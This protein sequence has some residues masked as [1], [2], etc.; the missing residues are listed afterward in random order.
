MAVFSLADFNRVIPEFKGDIAQLP[1]FIKR[2]DT[3]HGSLNDAGQK[4][5]I[6]HL[7]F[8]LSGKAF[9]I[10]ES[11]K[12]ETWALL[13][14]ALQEGLKISKSAS[15]LQNELINLK[16]QPDQSAKEFSDA[17]KEKLKELNDIIQ[18]QYNNDD[19]ITSFKSEYDKI[20]VRSFKEGLRPPL[21]HRIVN[22]ELKTL[23]ELIKK[24]VEEEPYVAVLKSSIGNNDLSDPP[25]IPN[26]N[27]ANTDFRQGRQ[28][29]FTERSSNNWNQSYRGYRPP[30]PFAYGNSRL[31]Q[32][33]YR[34]GNYD[35]QRPFPDHNIPHN[36]E[37]R[38]CIRCKRHG[39]TSDNCYARLD[40]NERV[41]RSRNDDMTIKPKGVSFLEIPQIKRPI[42]GPNRNDWSQDA[43]K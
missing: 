37:A 20:A 5:F 3:F 27:H 13:K 28:T 31:T 19:V 40:N 23:D 41:N 18:T 30:T 26:V 22:C 1:I 39:H 33:R 36:T 42:L 11:R 17:I 34:N 38:F 21:K 32:A 16:Q 25:S 6:T 10:F 8:K 7:I 43:R 9:L 35:V 12:Y 2:C 14:T 4:S 15:A 24:A 29:R